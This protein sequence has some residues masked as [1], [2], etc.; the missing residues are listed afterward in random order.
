[1]QKDEATDNAYVWVCQKSVEKCVILLE[2]EC[3]H[4][5]N[6]MLKSDAYFDDLK[7]KYLNRNILV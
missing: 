2:R 4:T 5:K 7:I 6:K 3:L 1:M